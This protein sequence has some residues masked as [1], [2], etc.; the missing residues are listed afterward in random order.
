[1]ASGEG[2]Y[3]L[4][5]RFETDGTSIARYTVVP[6]DGAPT[7]LDQPDEDEIA[8]L[9]ETTAGGDFDGDG[10]LDV[11]A[12]VTVPLGDGRVAF[13]FF[14]A[15]GLVVEEQRLFGLGATG[16]DDPDFAPLLLVAD[17]D[18]DGH[19]DLF[20]ATTQGFNLFDIVPD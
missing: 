1:V 9:A 12:M 4:A 17:F 14:V 10:Q 2:P 7:F 16:I 8:G 3:L 6:V 15:L 13:R 18:R 11:A 20:L 19:D 5:N